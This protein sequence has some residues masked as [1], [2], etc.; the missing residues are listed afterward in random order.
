M[1]HPKQIRTVQWNILCWE[2]EHIF[3]RNRD[4]RAEVW[5]HTVVI[6]NVS[7]WEVEPKTKT[8]LL[9]DTVFPD[10]LWLSLIISKKE[11]TWIYKM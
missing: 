5:Y 6:T 10:F 11:I 4:G 2:H 9:N 7:N 1:A 8:L 3:V